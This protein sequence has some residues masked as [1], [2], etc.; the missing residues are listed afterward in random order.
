MGE[1]DT[2]DDGVCTDEIADCGT[3]DDGVLTDDTDD[4]ITDDIKAKDKVL[5]VEPITTDVTTA[6]EGFDGVGG[7]RTGFGSFV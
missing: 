1:R 2:T 6:G 5:E 3:P 4:P 7:A